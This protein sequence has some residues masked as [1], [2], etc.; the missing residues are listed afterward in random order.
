MS[1]EKYVGRK[2]STVFKTKELPEDTRMYEVMDWGAKLHKMGLLP[3]E[4]GGNAGNM[5]FR[6][7]KGF[8]IT[9]G[10]V[11]KGRLNPRNFVQVLSCNMDVKTVVAEGELEPSSETFTHYL[12]YRERP[13]VNAIIHAHDRLVM[14]HAEKLRLKSTSVHHPYGTTDLAYEVEKSIGAQKF[15]IVRGHG[16]I[17]L[18]KSVWEAGKRIITMHQDAES[19]KD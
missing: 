11:N 18:G 4:S 16:V 6:N 9:A 14:D 15:L 10:G 13:D 3:A 19:P 2:F 8:V 5:S 17:S 7:S 12:I 1:D